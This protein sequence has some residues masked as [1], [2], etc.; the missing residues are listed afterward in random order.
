MWRDAG[1]RYKQ[2]N[3]IY[4]SMVLYGAVRRW[5]GDPKFTDVWFLFI[6]LFFISTNNYLERVSTRFQPQNTTHHL[7]WPHTTH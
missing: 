5:S 1:Q 7:I 6:F 4:G 2:K 3:L